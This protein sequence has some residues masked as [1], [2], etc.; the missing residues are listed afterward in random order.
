MYHLVSDILKQSKEKQCD[1]WEVVLQAD[2]DERGVSGKESFETMRQ[3]YQAMKEAD[4]GYNPKTRSAS[5]MAGGDGQKLHDYN[6]SGKNIC[7]DFV[8]QVME[9]AIK[10]GESNACMHRIVAAPTA[11]SCGVIPA[12]FLVAEQEFSLSE[13][14]MVE[15]MF[16]SAGVGSVIAENASLAGASGGCQAEIGSASAMAAAGLVYLQGG[17]GNQIADAAA[18]ALKN[19]LGLAC[20]PVGGLVEVPCIKRNVSGAVNA[21][22]SA[23]LAMAGIKSAIPVD[24]VIDAMRRI[25][26]EMPA[27]IKE[28]SLGGLATSPTAQQMKL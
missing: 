1:F 23:Q 14:K 10:M 28:T 21:L 3:M 2:A 11:G 12:V 15:A 20:D 26:N 13:D 22:T 25:G 19:M 6:V 24:E 7:G 18:F 4:L 5:K 27:S 16:V 17:D 8:G 9:K